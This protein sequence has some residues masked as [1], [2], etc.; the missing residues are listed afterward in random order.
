M[1]EICVKAHLGEGGLKSMCD[2]VKGLIEQNDC[3]KVFVIDDVNSIYKGN[4]LGNCNVICN[5]NDSSFLSA[6]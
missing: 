6:M 3:Y 4:M 2:I 5:L 1:I